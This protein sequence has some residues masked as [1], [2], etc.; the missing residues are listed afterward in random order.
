MRSSWDP[1]VH[2]AQRKGGWGKP[3]G[4]LQLFTGGAEGQC[5]ALLFGDGNR[6]W[7]N[8]IELHQGKV[9]L[10]VRKRFFTKTW[11]CTGTG[12]CSLTE[13]EKCLYS[14]LRHMVSFL[15]GLMWSQELDSVIILGPLQLGIFCVSVI[16][17]FYECSVSLKYSYS[18]SSTAV[19]EEE[20]HEQQRNLL[21]S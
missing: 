18:V 3:Y 7:G 19:Q 9:S 5:W 16:L 21:Y 4:G 10:G 6:I 11:L 20:N 15:G 14:A 12:K 8:G 17:W 13:C 2:S 1:L